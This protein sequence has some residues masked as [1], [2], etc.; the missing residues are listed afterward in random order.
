MLKTKKE[1]IKKF[2][3][4]CEQGLY[5]KNPYDINVNVEEPTPNVVS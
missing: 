1:M 5:L 2:T 4:G 3:T